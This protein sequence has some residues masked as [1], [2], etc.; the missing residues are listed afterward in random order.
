MKNFNPS[1][2]INISNNNSS[3]ATSPNEP[4]SSTTTPPATQRGQLTTTRPLK[5]SADHI[6]V[7]PR[8]EASQVWCEPIHSERSTSNVQTKTEL[9]SNMRARTHTRFH[10]DDSVSKQSDLVVGDSRQES[11]DMAMGTAI[12]RDLKRQKIPV[13]SFELGEA[14][15]VSKYKLAASDAHMHPTGYGQAGRIFDD[16]F[17]A[18]MNKI[19]MD[20]T[21]LM[22][23]PTTVVGTALDKNRDSGGCGPGYYIPDRMKNIAFEDLDAQVLTSILAENV[24][25]QLDTGVDASLA[26]RL[27]NNRSLSQADRERLDPMITGLNLGDINAAKHLLRKLYENKGVFTG[28]GEVTLAKEIVDKLNKSPSQA[29]VKSRIEA[30]IQLVEVAGVI[31]MPVVMH[32]DVDSLEHQLTHRNKDVQ[33]AGLAP[34]TPANLDDLKRLIRDPRLKN[35]TLIWAHA[36]GLGRFIAE[37]PN[38]I[39]ELS[40]LLKE[41]KNLMVDISWNRVAEQLTKS[42]TAIGNW[43]Q[44]LHDHD[45]Q[46]LFGS[47]VLSPVNSADSTAAD[48]W[49]QTR[50]KYT[51]LLGDLHI[52]KQANILHNNYERVFVASRPNVRKFEEKVLT[53]NFFE[54]VLMADP[55]QPLDPVQLRNLLA[56]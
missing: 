13:A 35:T 43:R 17:I 40:K 49:N 33:R 28:L 31:G 19:G 46:V 11:H 56:N 15:K 18:D 30:F 54:N 25:L 23:I 38:H 44:F 41:N 55:P 26:S 9:S 4:T 14:G 34:C 42:P 1:T 27:K 24:E 51:K 21:T 2:S 52:D 32:C 53:G 37:S 45:T 16:T 47:D 20:K 10:D 6:N 48:T 39:T 29:D 50:D 5:R 22:P 8:E 3:S 7:A 12:S 36:G